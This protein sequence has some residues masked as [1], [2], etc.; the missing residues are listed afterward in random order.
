MKYG[1]ER[2]GGAR[3]PKRRSALAAFLGFLIAATGCSAGGDATPDGR[4][5][6]AATSPGE[7]ARESTEVTRTL[8]FEAP[9]RRGG[10]VTRIPYG[11][12]PS[13]VGFV[14]ACIEKCSPPCPCTAPIQPVA[15]DVDAAGRVWVADTAKSRVAV[16]EPTSEL[17]F[18]TARTPLLLSASDLQLS[19]GRGIVLSQDDRH[20]AR[21]LSFDEAGGQTRS[22]LSFE[23]GRAEAYRLWTHGTRLFSTAFRTDGLTDEEVPVEV[24][25]D[26]GEAVAAEV[27]GRPFLDGWS[28]FQGYAGNRTVALEVS[29]STARWRVAIDL[30]IRQSVGG[31]SVERRGHVSWESEI[32]PDGTF[33]LL[34]FA[35]TEGRHATDGYWYL[36]VAPDG[37]VGPVVPLQGPSRRDDQQ[38]R[39]LTL[40]EDGNPVLMWA[41][42]RALRF[43]RLPSI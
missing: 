29:A 10:L 11:D 3:S 25:I 34:L 22:A 37:A 16:F 35:G 24:T 43:E 13:R 32:A 27:P 33:H 6:P 20:K 40:D 12:G 8:D 42:R 7:E 18:A 14:P 21:V 9:R 2:T 5:A 30:E 26:E 19:E 15:A 1:P 17:S 23:G 38:P 4:A 39:R 31:R 36:A 28:L 41:R